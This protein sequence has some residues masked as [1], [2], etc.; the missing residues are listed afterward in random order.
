MGNITL[1]KNHWYHPSERSMRSIMITRISNRGSRK[2]LIWWYIW[3]YDAA[4]LNSEIHQSDKDGYGFFDPDQPQEHR[5]YDI[6]NDMGLE[7]KYAIEVDS[8]ATLMAN[9]EYKQLMQTLY[10][11][12]SEICAM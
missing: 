8:S 12:Q 6:G 4:I 10:L 5:Q 7:E 9:E 11:R 2:R 1:P 3:W